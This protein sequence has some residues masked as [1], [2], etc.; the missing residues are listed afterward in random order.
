MDGGG[1]FGGGPA[2]GARLAADAVFAPVS[3]RAPMVPGPVALLVSKPTPKK[4]SRL[5]AALAVSAL[6]HGATALALTLAPVLRGADAAGESGKDVQSLP[7]QPALMVEL[8]T[9]ADLVS[10]AQPDVG[11]APVAAMTPPPVTDSLPVLAMPEGLA[12]TQP[13]AAALAM[14]STDLALVQVQPP[15]APPKAESAPQPAPKKAAKAKPAAQPESS[16][17]KAK[18]DGGGTQAGSA[19]VA[20]VASGLTKAQAADLTAEWGAKVRNRIERKRAYPKAAKGAAG[21]VKVRITVAAS[22]KLLEVS[23]AASS[24]NA[25]L[26]GAAVKA[27]KAAGKFPAAPKGLTKAS[28]SFTL[29]MKFQP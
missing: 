13:T 4:H 24:G 14:P 26:D 9:P 28:Y 6:L 12:P 16:G 1:T 22:G 17:V 18:G 20:K 2:E 19:G 21:T 11:Q 3:P 5:V 7:E 29:P 8:L 23:V 27:V 15:P 10:D 25:A